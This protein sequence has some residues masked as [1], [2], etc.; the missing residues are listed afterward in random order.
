MG[1]SNWCRWALTPPKNWF[2][3]TWPTDPQT[4]LTRA[5][6]LTGCPHIHGLFR[7]VGWALY[8][9][10]GLLR[11]VGN[12]SLWRRVRQYNI[13]RFTYQKTKQMIHQRLCLCLCLWGFALQ[14]LYPNT[15]N[16]RSLCIKNS[17]TKKYF[18]LTLTKM[19]PV[20]KV[21]FF[22]FCPFFFLVSSIF[23]FFLGC[24]GFAWF[25][26]CDVYSKSSVETIQN[27]P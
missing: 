13:K 26:L 22:W 2:P 17:K 25:S 23:W 15:W 20:T 16:K 3:P 1:F 18:E 12:R 6:K 4:S 27:S 19:D 24:L 8:H 5:E 9:L 21:F 11:R 7:R 10:R 14:R